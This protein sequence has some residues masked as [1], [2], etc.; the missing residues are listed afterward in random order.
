MD[1]KEKR[2]EKK[3][4]RP[5][6]GRRTRKTLGYAFEGGKIMYSMYLDWEKQPDRP[7]ENDPLVLRLRGVHKTPSEWARLAQDAEKSERW[8]DAHYYW[9]AGC[10][11]YTRSR[12]KGQKM[13]E[14]AHRCLKKWENSKKSF[15]SD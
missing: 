11:E 9:C 10:S 6:K 3:N 14:N 12:S 8:G 5:E 1:E 13:M 7:S 15:E 2:R 4:K